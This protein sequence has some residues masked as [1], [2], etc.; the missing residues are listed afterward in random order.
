MPSAPQMRCAPSGQ[1]P[2]SYHGWGTLQVPSTKVAM[3]HVWH[4]TISSPIGAG[5]RV[6]DLWALM[7]VGLAGHLLPLHQMGM[8]LPHPGAPGGGVPVVV[9]TPDLHLP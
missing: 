3:G 2:C 5:E 9:D 7:S 4:A 6:L 8:A 1:T